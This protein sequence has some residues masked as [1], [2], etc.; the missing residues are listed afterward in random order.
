MCIAKGIDT[1][2]L[3]TSTEPIPYTRMALMVWNIRGFNRKARKVEVL[4]LINK[5]DMEKIGILEMKIRRR[6]QMKVKEC[7]GGHWSTT[8]NTA[9]CSP[10]GGDS[11]WI[12]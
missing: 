12:L 7:F 6:N 2:S 9:E 4:S 10:K 5:F 1:A 3:K 11:I 8:L